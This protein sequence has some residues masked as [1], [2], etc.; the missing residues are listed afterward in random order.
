MMNETTVFKNSQFGDLRMIIHDGEPW[1]VSKDVCLAL[2]IK[3]HKDAIRKLDD[4]EKTG[5][6]L[7]DPHGR[8]QV[9]N[10]VSESG[11]YSL[12]LS[13]RKPEAHAFKRWVTH[14]VLPAIRRTGAYVAPSLAEQ[15]VSD[16]DTLYLIVEQLRQERTARLTAEENVRDVKEKLRATQER[17]DA[18]R[19]QPVFIFDGD[20]DSQYCC[21]VGNLAKQFHIPRQKMFAW[22][23]EHG[24]IQKNSPLPTPGA[25]ESGRFMIMEKRSGSTRY[26]VSAVTL[27]GQLYFSTIF[28]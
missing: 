28:E 22:L 16:P 3:N 2:S 7:T 20:P 11:L 18:L 4:D 5:V 6:V 12:V 25:I 24:Y 10:C 15:I 8:N 14:E 23:R 19:P 26:Y 13:S 17:L 9:T 1:F 21:S 27:A